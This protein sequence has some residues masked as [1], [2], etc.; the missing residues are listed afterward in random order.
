[1]EAR[2]LSG[3]AREDR[4][5]DG[6]M[7]MCPRLA[8]RFYGPRGTHGSA[9]A[10]RKGPQS[11]LLYGDGTVGMCPRLAERLYGPRGTHGSADAFPEKPARSPSF[12]PLTPTHHG[13]STL[14]VAQEN[15]SRMAWIAETHQWV[16]GN[17]GHTGRERKSIHA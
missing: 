1:M 15:T 6:T 3:R 5:G 17:T 12:R 11:L 14:R 13:V 8:E 9:I 7:G 2:L 10:F 4:N 16:P